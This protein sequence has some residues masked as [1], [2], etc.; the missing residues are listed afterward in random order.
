MVR[1]MGRLA[2]E[3]AA[4]RGKFTLFAFVLPENAISWDLVVAASWISSD[5]DALSYLVKKVQ[6]TLTKEELRQLSAIIRLDNNQLSS[7]SSETNSETGQ[8]Q[9]DINFFGR[10]I[11]KGYIFVAPV[12]DF[13]LSH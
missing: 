2:E 10:H 1:K 11:E 13:Q 9:S 7:V 5:T 4:E 12:E 3:I 6:S 8:E